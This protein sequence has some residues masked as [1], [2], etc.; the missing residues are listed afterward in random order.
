MI[1]ALSKLGPLA[2]FVGALVFLLA[3]GLFWIAV[4]TG[5][6]ALGLPLA[7]ALIKLGVPLASACGVVAGCGTVIVDAALNITG[8]LSKAGINHR[9]SDLELTVANNQINVQ[10]ALIR[11]YQIVYD[12]TAQTSVV[13]SIFRKTSPAEGKDIWETR[14]FICGHVLPLILD[15]Y[16]PHD[17][18]SPETWITYW[19]RLIQRLVS[20]H[21]R[22]LGKSSPFEKFVIY[23][24]HPQKLAI[25]IE[26][27]YYERWGINNSVE[28]AQIHQ[29]LLE[30]GGQ[31]G[32]IPASTFIPPL[33]S[34][35]GEHKK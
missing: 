13:P 12:E 31:E 34:M 33:K 14:K 11:H 24:L 10:E 1:G 32:A 20:C 8:R 18:N 28:E 29:T 7:T 16:P 25:K 19:D 4:A 5:A 6:L 26:R 22:V 21:Q 30:S 9:R 15:R 23:K 35:T 27:E 17:P 2:L 3:I